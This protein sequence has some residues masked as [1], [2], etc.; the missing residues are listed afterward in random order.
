[1]GTRAYI[2]SD[3]TQIVGDV[4]IGVDTVVYPRT[5]L[6]GGVQIGERCL[7]EERCNIVESRI[8]H[9][10][11]VS[12]GS[13]LKNSTL[14][15]FNAIGPKCRISDCQIGSLCSIAAGVVMDKAV[16]ADNTCVYLLPGVDAGRTNWASVVLPPDQLRSQYQLNELKRKT[17]TDPQNPCF[18]G[19]HFALRAAT[20]R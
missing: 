2:C 8:G 5:L 1:M 17:I 6:E 3:G 19:K 7:L 20:D 18:V 9:S 11:T 10:N 15:S 14:G 4:E 12:C 16:L 13:T